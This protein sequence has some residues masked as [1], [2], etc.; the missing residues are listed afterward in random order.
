MDLFYFNF[1]IQDCFID[2]FFQMYIAYVFQI[3]F[4]LFYFIIKYCIIIIFSLLTYG[5]KKAISTLLK[6]Y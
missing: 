6:A 3:Y 4:K 1:F 2:T 5:W